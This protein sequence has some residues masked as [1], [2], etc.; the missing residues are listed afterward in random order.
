MPAP[1]R[2]A[3]SP[4]LQ[5]VLEALR[6]G[7]PHSTADLAQRSGQCAVDTAVRELRGAPNHYAIEHQSR[8]ELSHQ[9]RGRLVHYYR[10]T[11]QGRLD[12]LLD[13][14]ARLAGGGR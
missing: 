12:A 5:R 11:S 1:C 8:W 7:A 14:A 13:E 3:T 10:L 9:G 2:L 4:R 6:D